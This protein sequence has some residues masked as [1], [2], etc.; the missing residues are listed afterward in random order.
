MAPKS[1]FTKTKLSKTQLWLVGILLVFVLL[2]VFIWLW[3]SLELTR[4]DTQLKTTKPSAII[5]GKSHFNQ[6]AKTSIS[7]NNPA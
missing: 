5:N 7:V 3:Y 6:I 2:L 4:I 1:I